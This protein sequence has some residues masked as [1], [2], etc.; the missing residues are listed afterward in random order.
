MYEKRKQEDEDT[1]E[2]LL[3]GLNVDDVSVDSVIRLGKRP[4][5][6]DAKPRPVKIVMASEEQKH[7]V[8][9]KSNNLPRNKEEGAPNI[10]M[11]QDLTPR[12]RMKRQE[13]VRE[14]KDRQA[15]GEK[16]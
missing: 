1:V 5:S 8:L 7:R 9:S 13:L 2:H 3:H 4:E 14:L 16:K 12:Q 10:F 6:S 15:K 11:H